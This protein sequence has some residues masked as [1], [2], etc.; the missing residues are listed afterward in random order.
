LDLTIR[1]TY[2]SDPNIQIRPEVSVSSIN[3]ADQRTITTLGPDYWKGSTGDTVRS[4]TSGGALFSVDVNLGHDQAPFVVQVNLHP[5]APVGVA[6][7]DATNGDA[8]GSNGWGDP[9][10]NLIQ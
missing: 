5:Y 9:V 4:T 6:A 2:A 8:L 10:F 1:Q 7:I 3:L